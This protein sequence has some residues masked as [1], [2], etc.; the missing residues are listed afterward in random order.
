M[1][2]RTEPFQEFYDLFE[3]LGSG[4]FA[5]VK[6]CVEKSTQRE[7][8]AKFV[9][10]RRPNSNSRKGLFREKILQEIEI[11]SELKHT[12][13]IELHEVFE[14]QQEIIIVLEMFVFQFVFVL[15]L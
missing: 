5:L 1:L 14:T 15:S 6:R 9:I 3:D 13:I 8:A 2:I 4:Q 7:F 12:N 10:K 11:L